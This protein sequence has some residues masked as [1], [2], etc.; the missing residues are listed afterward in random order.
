[1]QTVRRVLCVS[2]LALPLTLGCSKKERQ[3]PPGPPPLPAMGGNAA[4]KGHDVHGGTS[5]GMGMGMGHGGQM[6]SDHPPILRSRAEEAAAG[7]APAMPAGHGAPSEMPAA[8]AGGDGVVSGTIKLSD[9]IKDK[10]PKGATLFLIAKTASEAGIGVG[11]PVAV[12]RYAA[13]TWP[14]PFELTQANVML[15]GTTL[16]GKVV[17]SARVDQDGDAMTKQVGDL[18]GVTKPIVVPAKGIELVLDTVRT[19]EAGAPSP[20]NMGGGGMGGGQMPPG[21]PALP[22]GHPHP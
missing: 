16:Q 4:Q 2:L 10:A 20:P 12:Q 9:K 15:E 22:P 14:L 11:P 7:A 5:T 6:P 13:G 21:H 18:E 3:V 19:Q 1:M 8:Q 17:I